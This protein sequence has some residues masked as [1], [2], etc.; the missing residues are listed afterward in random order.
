MHIKTANDLL[1]VSKPIKQTANN[2]LVLPI[3]SAIGT[4][5][6]IKKSELISSKG[7]SK[8]SAKPTENSG[9]SSTN[10]ISLNGLN[11]LQ[12]ERLEQAFSAT[13]TQM[14]DNY[15]NP[16][17]IFS[18]SA[19][20]N[21]H[22]LNNNNYY[23]HPTFVQ[24]ASNYLTQANHYFNNNNT[25]S[26]ASCDISNI[27]Y[28]QPTTNMIGNTYNQYNQQNQANLNHIQQQQQQHQ[29]QS[30][31][32]QQHPISGQYYYYPTPESSPDVQL[33]FLNEAAALNAALNNSNSFMLANDNNNGAYNL[34][35]PVTQTAASSS[36]SSSSSSS[37]TSPN[38]SLPNNIVNPE[39]FANHSQYNNSVSNISCN[40]NNYSTYNYTNFS[41]NNLN[42]IT[43]V[44]D[45]YDV[46][47]QNDESLRTTNNNSKFSSNWYMSAAA[48]AAAAAFP[49]VNSSANPYK[50][51]ETP[52]SNSYFFQ[53]KF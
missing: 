16:T 48:A 29:L 23:Q 37:S 38:S 11:L 17:N 12:K 3:T 26:N 46:E 20:A 41:Q 27:Y 30:Q 10:R 22:L 50:N 42:K 15:S 8:K 14:N 52:N 33:Q 49:G 31:R 36:V 1:G 35:R 5:T 18:N 40:T 34:K 32:H 39:Q 45:V 21:S 19:N 13:S 53:P 4:S 25:N 9:S 47:H 6:K 2:Q 24:N 28:Q 7:S 51:E 43:S 44:S